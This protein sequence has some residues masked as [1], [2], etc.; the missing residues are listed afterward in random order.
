MTINK[1]QVKK[2][3]TKAVQSVYAKEVGKQDKGIARFLNYSP[4]NEG[5]ER[6]LLLASLI[7]D[8]EDRL[9]DW[10]I[11]AGAAKHELNELDL[12]REIH[13]AVMADKKAD[14]NWEYNFSE[15]FYID[16]KNRLSEIEDEIKYLER[17]IVNA[18]A[19]IK[20]EKYKNVPPDFW[21]TYHWDGDGV[22][23]W[24]EEDDELDEMP[25]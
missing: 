15:D 17:Y 14:K 13:K 1:K 23:I 6:D 4:R 5:E 12:K 18:K 21:L 8:A 22:N 3:V 10:E 11:K 19:L 2:A 7:N 24:D 25:F 20:N 9:L 16:T